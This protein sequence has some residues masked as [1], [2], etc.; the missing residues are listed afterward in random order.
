MPIGT[1]IT[2]CFYCTKEGD[3]KKEYP[4]LKKVQEGDEDHGS[5]ID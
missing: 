2:K 4:I 1:N 3:V 5:M